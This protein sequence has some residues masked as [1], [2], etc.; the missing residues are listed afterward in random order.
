MLNFYV[1]KDEK[2]LKFYSIE[3]LQEVLLKK[4]ENLRKAKIKKKE[5]LKAPLDYFFLIKTFQP[6]LPALSKARIS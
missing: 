4:I 6:L 3:F 1:L 2:S 5:L